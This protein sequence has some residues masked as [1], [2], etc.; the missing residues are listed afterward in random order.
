MMLD[1]GMLPF[2]GSTFSHKRLCLNGSVE[3]ALAFWPLVLS[4]WKGRG[5]GG[6]D[7]RSKEV[8]TRMHQFAR[9]HTLSVKCFKHANIA[10]SNCVYYNLK[11]INEP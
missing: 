10:W 6:Y 4:I 5:G 9:A 7:C 11:F 8:T 3:S 2:F 1:L